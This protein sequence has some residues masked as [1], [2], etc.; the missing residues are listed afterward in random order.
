MDHLK[1]LLSIPAR[2]PTGVSHQD[3]ADAVEA[4]RRLPGTWSVQR[5]IDDCEHTSVSI[6]Q[7]GVADADSLV[8][9]VWC[10]GG[11]YLVGLGQ[12]DFYAGLGSHIGIDGAMIAIRFAVEGGAAV[13]GWMDRLEFPRAE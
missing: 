5:D 3:Y 10:E 9:L 8:F 13:I 12:G 6:M 2:N 1:Q 7:E 11:R 4:V